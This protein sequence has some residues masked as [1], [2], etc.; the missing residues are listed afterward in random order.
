MLSLVCMYTLELV[1]RAVL[2]M[3]VHKWERSWLEVPPLASS[4]FRLVIYHIVCMGEVHIRYMYS[5][6]SGRVVV[7]HVR[8]ARAIFRAF[9]CMHVY[10]ECVPCWVTHGAT[11][12]ESGGKH[13]TPPY[14]KQDLLPSVRIGR[15][16][17]RRGWSPTSDPFSQRPGTAR[18]MGALHSRFIRA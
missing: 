16:G 3:R 12:G 2:G 4:P 11:I 18:P 15:P 13:T 14:A 7:Y 10:S 5:Y 6:M 9:A 17:L 1:V 8:V